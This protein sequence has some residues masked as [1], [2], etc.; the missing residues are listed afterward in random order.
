MLQNE[1]FIFI[2]PVAE[3]DLIRAKIRLDP[4]HPLFKGHF[5]GQPVLPG[6]VMVEIVKELLEIHIKKQTRLVKASDIKFL[7]LII[8]EQDKLIQIVL[9]VSFLE[10]QITANAQLL[11]NDDLLFKFKGTFEG[12]H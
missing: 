8:P 10:G 11:D 7:S 3:G 12:K 1:L 2:D 6:V 9:K 5:P 4:M